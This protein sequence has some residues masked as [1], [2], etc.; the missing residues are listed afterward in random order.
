MNCLPAIFH[1][2]KLAEFSDGTC[3]ILALPKVYKFRYM[4]TVLSKCLI[5]G[6]PAP[7]VIS[8]PRPESAYVNHQSSV[9]S[10]RWAGRDASLFMVTLSAVKRKAVKTAY[11][12]AAWREWRQNSRY[13]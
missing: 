8:G 9:S 2:L 7:Y 4:I 5:L 6:L 13:S 12:E 1:V 10:S 11:S 3:A